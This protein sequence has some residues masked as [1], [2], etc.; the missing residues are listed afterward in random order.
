MAAGSGS[1]KDGMAIFDPLWTWSSP[2]IRVSLDQ[3]LLAKL[4]CHMIW[5]RCSQDLINPDLKQHKFSSWWFSR[6]TKKSTW[7][8]LKTAARGVPPVSRRFPPVSRQFPP[9]HFQAEFQIQPELCFCELLIGPCY[10]LYQPH[11]LHFSPHQIAT[12]VM[13]PA[14]LNYELL[15]HISWG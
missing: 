8:F 2:R 13:L 5:G 7:D 1:S 11:I 10:R 14:S 4:M 3:A 6:A 15:P 9:A 12:R